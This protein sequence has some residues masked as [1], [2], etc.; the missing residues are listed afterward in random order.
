MVRGNPIVK[1]CVCLN[2]GWVLSEVG[3]AKTFYNIGQLSHRG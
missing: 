1:Y 3:L 2:S